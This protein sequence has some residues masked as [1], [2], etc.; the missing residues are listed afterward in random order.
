MIEIEQLLSSLDIKLFERIYSQSS[1]N[2]KKSLLA[3]QFATRNLTPNYCYLEIGSYI[4][5]S[6]QPHLLDDQCLHI[7]S[8][9]KR[10]AQQ[11]DNRGVNYKYSN[12]STQ[13]MLNNLREVAPKRIDKIIC[14]DGDTREISPDKIQEK[15]QLCFID[16]EHTD[17]AVFSDFQF[18]LTTLSQNGAI[19]FHDA[20][21]IN[22]GLARI[23]QYLTEVSIRFR[24]YNLPDIVFVIEIGDYPLHQS[25]LIME[26]LLNNHVGYLASLQHND[27]YRQFANKPIFRT[28]RAIRSMLRGD[29]TCE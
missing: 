14:I 19:L 29:N 26:R 3:C 12:N 16:G 22:N 7:Y 17:E 2:D 4:G 13:R 5:G 23:I 20:P 25:P 21:I 27:H 18:C 28:Y 1:N 8:I 15:I 11:P 9:D 6:I 10:P 24:A